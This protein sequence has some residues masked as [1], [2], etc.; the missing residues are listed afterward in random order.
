M[1]E[2]T[3]RAIQADG[4]QIRGTIS[5]ASRALALSELQRQGIMPLQLESGPSGS[6]RPPTEGLLARLGR[7]R[8]RITPQQ[9]LGLTRDL[10]TMLR[11]G[12]PLDRA[13]QVLGRMS[14]DPALTRLLT[15]WLE[16]VKAGKGLSQ[17][18]EPRQA[19]LGD[20]YINMV[21]AGEAGG[22][23]ATALSRLAEHLEQSRQLRASV[24][25]ALTYPA[26][27]M[28]VA[29][30]SVFIMLAFVVPQFEAL[31]DD[32]G[33]G[34]PLATQIVVALGDLAAEG[35]W[36]FMLL[37]LALLIAIDRIPRSEAGRLWLDRQWLAL[38]WIGQVIRTLE[39]ARFARTMGTLLGSGVSMLESL[40][41]AVDTVGNRHL[42][43]ALADMPARIKQG[44]AMTAAME[45]TG[46]FSPLA[47]QMIQVGEESGKLEPMLLELARVQDDEVQAGVKRVVS[48]L[49]PVLILVLGIVIA[50]I[51]LAILMGI[52]SVNELV[53]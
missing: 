24:V 49:E 53:A 50:G 39:T 1:P 51:I 10:A 4:R 31:F 12:L 6:A 46:L 40:K 32:M 16:G 11:A 17:A 52:M 13:L 21:R 45:P 47:I 2:F 36:A 7:R 48:I 22:Q 30:L 33:D 3:Y 41:I 43:G 42:R 14:R 15:E 38:P 18:L 29:A 5:A 35:W 19:L 9:I 20:F 25:S 23:L 26:I 8:D 37:L 27:L 28:V 44:G 34:L